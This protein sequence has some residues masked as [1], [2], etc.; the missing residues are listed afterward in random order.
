MNNSCTGEDKRGFHSEES[1]NAESFSF[2]I[3]VRDPTTRTGF[4]LVVSPPSLPC[5]PLLSVP[6]FL[7]LSLTLYPSPS[8]LS[9]TSLSSSL[10]PTL[11]PSLPPYL[12]GGGSGGSPRGEACELVSRYTAHHGVHAPL[13]GDLV[14]GEGELGVALG[15]DRFRT[16]TLDLL[17][18]VTLL[19]G[20]TC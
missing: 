11:P 10:S 15:E 18:P 19:T 3:N 9:L 17:Y 5:P 7:L 6:P 16:Q 8:T 14:P 2:L 20:Q 13:T 1:L 12:D 4:L